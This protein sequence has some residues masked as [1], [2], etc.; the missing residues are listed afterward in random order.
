MQLWCDEPFSLADIKTQS[1]STA[2]NFV[3]TLS[4][5]FGGEPKERASIEFVF[6][7]LIELAFK[8]RS[9]LRDGNQGNFSRLV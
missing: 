9:Q 6:S 2:V 1:T 8:Q 5:W 7:S 4:S 3:T